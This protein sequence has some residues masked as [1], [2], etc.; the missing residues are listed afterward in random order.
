MANTAGF[1][2]VKGE[3]VVIIDADLQDPPEVILDM[4]QKIQGRAMTLCMPKDSKEI[5]K[6]G[7]R[8]QRQSGFTVSCAF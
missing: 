1:R 5:R 2:N 3:A 7:L 6:R 8:K 4:Y